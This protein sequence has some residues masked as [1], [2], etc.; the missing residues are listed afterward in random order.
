MKLRSVK[1]LNPLNCHK[2]TGITCQ[3]WQNGVILSGFENLR[4]LLL[5]TA[6]K[7]PKSG[8]WKFRKV[9]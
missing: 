6:L 3:I 9:V 2:L 5:I 4:L 1:S 8:K 7:T